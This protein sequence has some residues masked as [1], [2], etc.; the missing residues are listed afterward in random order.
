M[1]RPGTLD[2]L[3]ADLG[4]MPVELRRELRPAMRKAAQPILRDAK[5]R[6]AWSSRIPG[7]IK[8][9][10]SFTARNPGVR[11][12][13][14]SRKAP[15]GRPF[16]HGSGR[17]KRLRHPVFGNR[18]LWVEQAPRPFF[19]PAVRAGEGAVLAA[20]NAAVLAAARSAGFR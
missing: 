8:I 6:A 19:F 17:N 20:T 2:A 18:E 15:H 9:G 10:T 14:D 7:A 12:I 11:L 13:V 16:E 4:K 1:R 3:I 5:A